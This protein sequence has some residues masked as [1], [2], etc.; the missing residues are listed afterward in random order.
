M[1]HGHDEIQ[2]AQGRADFGKTLPLGGALLLVGGGLCAMAY[3]QNQTHFF[4]SYLYGFT[5]WM[6]LTLGCFGLTLLHHTVRGRW[7]LPLLRIWEAGGGAPMLIAMG[8]AFLPIMAGLNEIYHWTD[9]HAPFDAVVQGKRWWLNDQFFLMRQGIYWFI[10]VVSAAVLRASSLR[11]DRTRN[12]NEAIRRTNIAAPMLFLFLCMVTV[13]WTD[14][15]MSVQVH[16]FSTIWGALFMV[17][18]GLMGLAFGGMVFMLNAK[19][20]PYNAFVNKQ[21]TKDIG[22]MMFAFTMLW[23]YLTLSQY[24]I[25]YSANLPEE[26]PYFVYRTEG[27]YNIL[28]VATVL[29]SFFIPFLLL[30]APRIKAA[31][32]TLFGAAALIFFVR[33]IDV[34]WVVIP[35][36][37]SGE[38]ARSGLGVQVGD[39]GSLL[40]IGGL[41]LIVF[42]LQMKRAELV[43][44]HDPRVQEA[45]PEGAQHAS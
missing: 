18:Q 14:W 11:E 20:A 28:G 19:K 44:L 31:S 39:L 4:Q 15:V 26:T 30:L 32:N 43:P 35:S 21:T 29:G 5:F 3:S 38:A 12:A 1:S 36:F 40:A 6:I 16:W 13:C 9:K 42:A 23:G 8:L 25:I 34:F 33:V 22:N 10:W 37:Y 41:W 17:Y 45:L 24:L 27:G 2:P 7:S